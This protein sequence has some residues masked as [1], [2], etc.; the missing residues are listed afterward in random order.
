MPQYRPRIIFSPNELATISATT[1]STTT[2]RQQAGSTFQVMVSYAGS[3]F[4][5][6]LEGQSDDVI[7]AVLITSAPI[8]DPPL[9]RPAMRR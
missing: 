3:R 4:G 2:C 7:I 9:L 8:I 6:Q 1:F 5:S